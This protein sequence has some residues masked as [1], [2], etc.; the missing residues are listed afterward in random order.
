M[1]FSDDVAIIPS[2]ESRWDTVTAQG[3][4]SRPPAGNKVDVTTTTYRSWSRLCGL[5]A[6]R[7]ALDL[8][9][10]RGVLIDEP[11]DAEYVIARE[12]HRIPVLW[13]DGEVTFFADPEDGY[14]SFGR[15]YPLM[16]Q[17]SV[18]RSTGAY[19][20]HQCWS[21]FEH[22][23]NVPNMGERLHWSVCFGILVVLR[24]K[25]L[26]WMN[27]GVHRVMPVALRPQASHEH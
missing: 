16:E 14:A 26:V 23:G 2:P 1:R 25:V 20:M 4:Y 15:L 18:P 24:Q 17:Y 27:Q 7:R 10:G 12:A 11:G 6:R 9:H 3:D 22:W 5:E 8:R 13:Q 21:R 19:T